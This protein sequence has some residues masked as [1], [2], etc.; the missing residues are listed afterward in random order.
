MKQLRSILTRSKVWF[1]RRTLREQL[2][3]CG[4]VCIAFLWLLTDAIQALASSVQTS[5]VASAEFE[6]QQLWLDR[7]SALDERLER[8][9]G[10]LDAS[11]T[12]SVNQMLEVM[13]QIAK[14]VGLQTSIARPVSRR[15]NVFTEH[16]LTVPVSRATLRTLIDFENAVKS[17]YPYLGMDYMLIQPEPAAPELLRGEVRVTSFELN[18]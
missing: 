1:D 13:D 6:T 10:D 7:E 9:L 17:H 15:G 18:R 2:L 5:R 16:V 3:L 11:K 4:I 14:Q 8:A 12:Y